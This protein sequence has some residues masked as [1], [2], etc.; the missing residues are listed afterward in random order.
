MSATPGPRVGI[1]GVGNIGT[2]YA[3][4]IESSSVVQLTAVCDPDVKQR[5]AVA[6]TTGAEAFSS[7]HDLARSGLCDAVIVCTPPSTHPQVVRDCLEAGI[8]VLCEKPFA[9]G[10]TDA[11]EMFRTAEQTDRL[12]AMASKFRYVPDVAKAAG[13]IRSG[14]I[15][16]PTLIDVTFASTV[17]MSNRWNSVRSV[18][19]G[20]VLIDNG[21]H[22]ADVVRFLVGP[23]ARVSAVQGRTASLD[24]VE[25][26]AIMLAETE[27]EAIATIHVSWSMPA[28]K[29][30]F[31][32][33]NGTEGALKIGWTESVQRSGDAGEWT[34]FG[35]G[36][37]KID[38]LRANVESFVSASVG[39]DEM[40]ISQE[41]VMASVAVI[42][43]AYE[44]IRT[45]QWVD[46][47]KPL[48][49]AAFEEFGV[50]SQS[51]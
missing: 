12:L 41:D 50:A 17:D 49:S 25:D 32:V 14:A 9:I 43:A 42:D 24:D 48:E 45:R 22:A 20:G 4:A 46:V 16:D 37:S 10:V 8:D 36:Y 13:L 29:R 2:A 31:V 26:T 34:H 35:P 18:S 3:M 33:V 44:A 15:G 40:R 21:T 19:G 47:R 11:A 5:N 1:V 7:H 28:H 30:S 27:C 51:G 6:A 23:I 39:V 38:A